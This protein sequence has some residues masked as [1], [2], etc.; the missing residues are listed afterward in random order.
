M[1][2]DKP[3]DGSPAHSPP[4][5]D[6]DSVLDRHAFRLETLEEAVEALKQNTATKCDMSD[7]KSRLGQQCGMIDDLTQYHSQLK[8]EV[9]AQNK[10]MRHGFDRVEQSI[11]MLADRIPRMDTYASRVMTPRASMLG[12]RE[13]DTPDI[14]GNCPEE[15]VKTDDKD[16]D[17]F[18]NKVGSVADKRNQLHDKTTF[19][20]WFSRKEDSSHYTTPGRDSRRQR[21]S[22]SDDYNRVCKLLS[23]LPKFTGTG[24]FE[25][26]LHTFNQISNKC[27]VTR[28]EKAELL[29]MCMQEQAS[30]YV[31]NLTEDVRGNLEQ[32]VARLDA[33]YGE[34]K[35]ATTAKMKLQTL[36]Q[37][38]TETEDEFAEKVERM[39]AIAYKK[40]TDELRNEM[41]VHY[42][43]RGCANQKAA[44]MISTKMPPCEELSEALLTY[45]CCVSSQEA[46]LGAQQNTARRC[47]GEVRRGYAD[48]Y[49]RSS[50]NRR[51][52]FDR[53]RDWSRGR[54]TNARWRSD[55]SRD[56]RRDWSSDRDSYTNWARDGSRDNKRDWSRGRDRYSNLKQRDESGDRGRDWNR[57]RDAYRDWGRGRDAN[58]DWSRSRRDSRQW[59]RDWNRNSSGE[60]RRPWS[61]NRNRYERS[62]SPEGRRRETLGYRDN[63]A[64]RSSRH[65]R[66][67]DRSSSPEARYNRS[68]SK[69]AYRRNKD[70]QSKNKESRS[71]SNSESDSETKNE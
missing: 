30:T 69:E 54:D 20:N 47:E 62:G 60:G 61:R 28:D 4:R 42:F 65:K 55:R 3:N 11:N 32:L 67:H 7:M 41:A 27:Q 25:A 57:R 58:R 44:L 23:T 68:Y 17:D 15:A 64:S 1:G 16:D 38:V 53:Q 2:K 10:E 37:C 51:W 46:I 18:C 9:A 29:Q 40:G 49:G 31:S 21:D 12:G 5:F 14:H 33:R 45:K 34:D 26:F 43:V 50:S 71:V 24:P 39:V 48:D 6:A 52:D 8:D 36:R 22:G 13:F 35:N 19:G 56:R 70:S 66:D 63:Y 59:S